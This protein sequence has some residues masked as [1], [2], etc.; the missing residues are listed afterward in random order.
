MYHALW[1]SYNIGMS[2]LP[3][4]YAKAQG[5]RPEDMHIRQIK[6]N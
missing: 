2:A 3:D 1:N 5:H 4:M 6:Y